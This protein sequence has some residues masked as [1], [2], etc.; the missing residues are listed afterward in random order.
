[1]CLRGRRSREEWWPGR[2]GAAWAPHISRCVEPMG[3]APHARGSGATRPGMSASPATEALTRH[4]GHDV[5]RRSL[6]RHTV[7][8]GAAR[9]GATQKG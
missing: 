9:I 1:V 8:C 2:A 3:G 6:G 4:V 7:K 5:W